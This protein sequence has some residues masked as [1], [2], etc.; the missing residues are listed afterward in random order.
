MERN[1]RHA[2]I[3][4]ALLG[5]LL[6]L[7]AVGAA[8][9]AAS[10]PALYECGKAA[11]VNKKYTGHYT[12]K[13]CSAKVETG[14]KYELQEW[15]KTAKKGKVKKFKSLGKPRANLE[16]PVLGGIECSDTK[17]TGEFTGP[18]SAGD[19]LVIFTGCTHGDQ[20]CCKN[21]SK[22]GEIKVNPLKA[23]I[24]YINASEHNVG[25]DL[26][27][28]T[29]E[30]D[31]ELHCGDEG[32]TTLY[33]RTVGSVVGEIV[34]ADQ[35]VHRHR[36]GQLEQRA[37]KQNIE[38]LEGFPKDTLTTEACTEIAPKT[39]TPGGDDES[40]EETLAEGKGETL[41]LKA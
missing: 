34:L 9:A 18:K 3:I 17:D 26:S 27:P 13:T 21:T 31:A 14:G 37:G 7:A 24:G 28:E 16:I 41:E 36:E 20:P 39:C 2:K 35:H 22:S 4:T 5:A 19:I 11:K 6:A 15:S 29:G 25:F 32:N 1:I 10:E 33:L 40:G 38:K 30:V 8:T 23:E 12:N